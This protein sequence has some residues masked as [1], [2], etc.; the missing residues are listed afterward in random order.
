MLSSMS[1]PQFTAWMSYANV[2]PFGDR[3]ADLRA[4]IIAS[5]IANA[6]RDPRKPALQPSDFMPFSE[7]SDNGP[8]P[9]TS[10]RKFR[11][12]MTQMK[13]VFGGGGAGVPV[14]QQTA[15]LVEDVF[16]P[17]DGSAA[18]GVVPSSLTP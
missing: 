6:H 16:V 17:N 2:Q 15:R 11:A 7:R 5:T 4:G 13:N 1:W 3:R 14:P 9:L 10:K 12:I 18:A 8:K